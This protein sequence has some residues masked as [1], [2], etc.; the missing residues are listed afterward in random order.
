MR[1]LTPKGTNLYLTENI[2]ES[3]VIFPIGVKFQHINSKL[4][5]INGIEQIE[6]TVKVVK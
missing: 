2:E 4:V 6:I 1:I 5:Y 3:E